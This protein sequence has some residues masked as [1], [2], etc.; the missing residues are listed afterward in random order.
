MGILHSNVFVVLYSALTV[1]IWI[2]DTRTLH[3]C[4]DEISCAQASSDSNSAAAMGLFGLISIFLIIV[5]R[6]ILWR[7]RKKQG[8]LWKTPTLEIR[9][10]YKQ[11][12]SWYKSI[13]LSVKKFWIRITS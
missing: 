12:F 13:P 9:A 10:T 7:S 3:S 5:S 8:E 1:F 2:M 6:V 11:I 4:S